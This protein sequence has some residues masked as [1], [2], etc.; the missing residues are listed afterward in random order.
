MVTTRKARRT[1]AGRLAAGWDGSALADVVLAGAEPLGFAAGDTNLYRYVGNDAIG[2]LDPLG[3]QP[4]PPGRLGPPLSEEQLQ[5]L[6]NMLAMLR[7][8]FK[9][10]AGSQAFANLL[11]KYKI[12]DIGSTSSAFNIAKNMLDEIDSR[13]NNGITRPIKP[14]GEYLTYFGQKT[15]KRPLKLQVTTMLHELFHCTGWSHSRNNIDGNL[16]KQFAE[17]MMKLIEQA[18]AY[19]D[20]M[21]K[22]PGSPLNGGPGDKEPQ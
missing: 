22:Y 16:A 21:K 6:Q 12:S 18:Q 13:G 15:F 4:F 19:K 8:A 17:E 9:E 2:E 20:F 7:N 1:R 11:K 5:Y 14:P 10:L 3:T